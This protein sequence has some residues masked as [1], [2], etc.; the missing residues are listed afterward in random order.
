MTITS[1][2]RHLHCS[3][4]LSSCCLPCAEPLGVLVRVA[5]QACSTHHRGHLCSSVELERF[6]I[7][8]HFVGCAYLLRGFISTGMD[9]FSTY[10]RDS[11]R[12]SFRRESRTQLDSTSAS[13]SGALADASYIVQ[14]RSSQSS[15]GFMRKKQFSKLCARLCIHS[16]SPTP[17]SLSGSRKSFPFGDLRPSRHVHRRVLFPDQPRPWSPHGKYRRRRGGPCPHLWGTRASTWTKSSAG[18][19]R[20]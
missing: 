2:N 13:A 4:S 20:P 6:L 14:C 10:I 3:P 8:R 15:A 12:I 5:P 16:I 11:K 17:P 19:G 18:T 9:F 7:E 1:S